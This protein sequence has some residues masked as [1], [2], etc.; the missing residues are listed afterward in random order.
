MLLPW[1]LSIV[2]TQVS[3]RASAGFSLVG[4]ALMVGLLAAV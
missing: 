3:P 4:V 1:L 2:L